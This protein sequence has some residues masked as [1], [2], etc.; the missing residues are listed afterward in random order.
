MDGR[1]P[2][3]RAANSAVL[4]SPEFQPLGAST[5]DILKSAQQVALTAGFGIGSLALLT[6]T[7]HVNTAL[8]V[9]AAMS[10]TALLIAVVLEITRRTM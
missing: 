9:L 10:A 1:T 4:D 7:T 8:L 2:I 5:N 6:S 3:A